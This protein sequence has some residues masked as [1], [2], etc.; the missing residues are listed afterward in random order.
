[1]FF[2]YM[3]LLLVWQYLKACFDKFP[4]CY[5]GKNYSD[6]WSLLISGTLH[7][8]GEGAAEQWRGWDNQREPGGDQ[9]VNSA[10]VH[11]HWRFDSVSR[12]SLNFMSEMEQTRSHTRWS[13][14]FGVFMCHIGC[15]TVDCVQ[16]ACKVQPSCRWVGTQNMCVVAGGTRFP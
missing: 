6:M 2:V 10:Q 11:P 12:V 3:C 16:R 1:M 13:S 7:R 15:N 9:H 4:Y 8:R 5:K 14:M